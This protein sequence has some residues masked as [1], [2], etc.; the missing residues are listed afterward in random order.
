MPEKK[1]IEQ[2]NKINKENKSNQSP[3]DKKPKKTKKSLM[4]ILNEACKGISEVAFISAATGA[5]A[6]ALFGC[7]DAVQ[8]KII[9]KVS[10]NNEFFYFLK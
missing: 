7:S 8:E 6:Y 4:Q 2:E 3:E 9:Q 5:S 10:K 1:E